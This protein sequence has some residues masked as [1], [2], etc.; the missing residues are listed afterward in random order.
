MTTDLMPRPTLDGLP[1]TFV[2]HDARPVLAIPQASLLVRHTDASMSV[3]QTDTIRQDGWGVCQ[4]AGTGAPAEA[5]VAL[6]GGWSVD[7]L[8]EEFDG[9]EDA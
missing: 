9:W 1:W 6:A 2:V 8:P 3:W 4:T 7:D 5:W